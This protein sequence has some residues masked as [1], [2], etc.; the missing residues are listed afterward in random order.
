LA[1][2]AIGAM[3]LSVLLPRVI[4]P[5]V[6]PGECAENPISQLKTERLTAQETRI[7]DLMDI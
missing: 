1:I 3:P 2:A 7:I 5:A 6:L 4:T